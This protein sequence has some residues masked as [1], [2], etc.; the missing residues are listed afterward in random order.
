M[1][2]R[3]TGLTAA[4]AGLALLGGCMTPAGRVSQAVDQMTEAAPIPVPEL[5]DAARGTF[6]SEWTVTLPANAAA[7]GQVESDG[8]RVRVLFANDHDTLFVCS[9]DVFPRELRISRDG[10]YLYLRVMGKTVTYEGAAPVH[11][12][13]L[14]DLAARRG[15]GQIAVSSQPPPRP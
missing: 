14:Y 13:M 15:L 9:E 2:A 8:R 4:A 12:V 11:A 7:A 1:G 3:F 5:R 10:R 6:M